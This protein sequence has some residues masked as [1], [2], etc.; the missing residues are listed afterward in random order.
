VLVCV[1]MGLRGPAAEQGLP[2]LSEPGEETS[3]QPA[4][5]LDQ[6]LLVFMWRVCAVSLLSCPGRI[7]LSRN[8]EVGGSSGAVFR[9]PA[10][11]G[12]EVRGHYGGALLRHEWFDD[13]VLRPCQAG[14]DAIQHPG[15]IGEEDNEDRRA[16]TRFT[17]QVLQ[18]AKRAHFG[19]F[20]AQEE[21]TGGFGLSLEALRFHR[22]AESD[23]QVA[24][25]HQDYLEDLPSVSYPAPEFLIAS[26]CRSLVFFSPSSS[27]GNPPTS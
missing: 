16:E 11:F 1:R 4:D 12:D 13:H 15:L 25:A 22:I 14:F 23:D 7:P 27:Y 6:L 5:A 20:D 2:A 21:H 17:S 26:S 9:R 3:V 10:A 24:G 19:K 18:H 8:P